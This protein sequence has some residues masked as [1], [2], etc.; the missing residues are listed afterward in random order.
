MKRYRVAVTAWTIALVTAVFGVSFTVNAAD[1]YSFDY[2]AK[3]DMRKAYRI[4]GIY[5]FKRGD[6]P[7]VWEK[8]HL[9]PLLEWDGS[10]TCT[11]PPVFTNKRNDANKA[12]QDG[13]DRIGDG[14]AQEAVAHDDSQTD[15][16]VN[17]DEST[18]ENNPCA[19]ASDATQ[20][21][22]AMEADRTADPAQYDRTLE[23][24]NQAAT[25]A[26]QAPVVTALADTSG[27]S[28]P[29]DPNIVIPPMPTQCDPMSPEFEACS[30]A[31]A[32]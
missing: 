14:D 18:D 24:G 9:P 15:D 32:Q 4:C 20:C 30:R 19:G 21:N 3:N 6:C 29:V 12:L 26:G 25:E 1:P 10:S 31:A 28:D 17:R 11:H 7:K 23:E 5:Q 22:T 2:K 13:A 16:A 27:D 8:C